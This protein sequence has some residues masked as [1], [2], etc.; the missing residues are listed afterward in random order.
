L[1]LKSEF[2][3]LLERHLSALGVRWGLTDEEFFR[4]SI[5]GFLE[6]E[7]G[8]KV[9]R[10]TKFDDEGIVFGCP[11]QVEI[12]IAISD[13]K[14]I[15]IEIESYARRSDV[16]IF[17]RKAEL[18]EKVKGKKPSKLLLATPYAEEKAFEAASHLGIEIYTKV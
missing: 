13:G 12:D 15:L 16:Y 18:Y 14:E 1:S 8:L 7:L 2:L 9:E 17:K 6:K 4:K 5:R 10:W 11:S 3:E